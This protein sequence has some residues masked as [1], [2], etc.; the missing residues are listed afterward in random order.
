MKGCYIHFDGSRTP[1]VC[2]KINMQIQVLRRYFEVEEMELSFVPKNL[3]QRILRMLPF[4]AVERE[5]EKCLTNMH[6]PDFVYIRRT[7]ADRLFIRFLQRLRKAYPECRILIEL[8]TYPYD[9]DEF[10][11]WYRLPYYCKEVY[12]RRKIPALIDRYVTVSKDERIFGKETIR[13][14]NGILLE[15]VKT[16]SCKDE[17]DG[18]IDMAAAAFMQKQHGYERVIKGLYHYYQA[19]GNRKVYFHLAGEGPEKS[20]YQKLVKKYQL[21]KNVLF[22]PELVGEQLDDFFER[23]DI[24]VSALGLY[25]NGVYYESSL[26]SREYLARGLPM[27]TGCTVDVFEKKPCGYYCSFPNDRSS[28]DIEQVLIFCDKLYARGGQSVRKDIRSYAEE[29]VSMDTAMKAVVDYLSNSAAD[30][31]NEGQI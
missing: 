12:H 28:I 19:G 29:M 17:P 4:G 23:K 11:K 24:A 18:R 26:K 6:R 13:I 10:G 25:K 20:N 5:Y 3:L 22:Y 7:A 31:R 1:G 21:E 16:A 2:R 27:I 15:Q 14:M 30:R 9:K 8:Y